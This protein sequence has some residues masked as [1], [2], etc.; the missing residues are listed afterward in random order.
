MLAPPPVL[1]LVVLIV[2]IVGGEV[3]SL[4][5][6]NMIYFIKQD[7]INKIL[8]ITFLI[9]VILISGGL[10]LKSGLSKI[11]GKDLV[12]A[13]DEIDLTSFFSAPT[14]VLI[15]SQTNKVFVINRR[16]NTITIFDGGEKKPIINLPTGGKGAVKAFM[17]QSGDIYVLNSN[18]YITIFPGLGLK[19]DFGSDSVRQILESRKS[20]VVGLGPIAFAEDSA[21]Q[22]LYVLNE[23][24]GTLAIVDLGKQNIKI[25]DIKKIKIGKRP[26]TLAINQNTHKVYVVNN[27]DGNL[28]IFDGKTDELIKNLSVGKPFFGLKISNDDRVFV[29][30]GG[31][32]K[33]YVIDGLKDEITKEFKSGGRGSMGMEINN[34]TD[35]LYISNYFD[36]SLSVV[37]A[38]NYAILKNIS[39]PVGANSATPAVDQNLNLIFVANTET[40]NIS[41]IDGRRDEIIT[42]TE[43]GAHP[44]TPEI[45]SKTGEVYIPN[46]KSDS[47]T[48]I[49]R[50]KDGN[51]QEQTIP[52]QK[53][54]VSTGETFS[55]PFNL[56]LNEKDNEIYI[57]NK[58]GGDFIIVDTKN[59]KIK[60]KI[61]VGKN[62]S[63]MIFV[64]ETSDIFVASEDE[65]N[66]IQ[67]NLLSK[68][69][70]IIPVGNRP[71]YLLFNIKTK[72][73]YAVNY[74]NGDISV[75]D[76]ER[77]VNFSRVS[78]NGIPPLKTRETSIQPSFQAIALNSKDNKIYICDVKNNEIGI[79]NGETDEL[80]QKIKVEF[81]PYNLLY[82]KNSNQLYVTSRLSDKLTVIDGSSDQVKKTL[83]VGSFP[84]YISLDEL[85]NKVYVSSNDGIK[86]IDSDSLEIISSKIYSSGYAIK[87]IIDQGRQKLFILTGAENIL[88]IASLEDRTPLASLP[89]FRMSPYLINLGFGRLEDVVFNSKTNK[90]FIALAWADSLAVIDVG[91]VIRFEAVISN[92]GIEKNPFQKLLREKGSTEGFPR[93]VQKEVHRRIIHLVLFVLII[94]VFIALIT[95]ILI[96]FLK[97]KK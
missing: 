24:E 89:I 1:L 86:I 35:K 44:L 94:C 64:P 13:A 31:E 71:L 38:R 70:K 91:G 47:I 7:K 4:K 11:L 29:L 32:D 8:V 88:D 63:E 53:E 77:G 60:E 75:I 25:A 12:F 73:L 46:Y 19:N 67:Y 74:D 59:Y 61:S 54:I 97:N 72:K 57:L 6:K 17:N 20:V 68:S 30:S 66:V 83:T 18:S 14:R 3:L 41:I 9:F 56:A 52:N 69:K 76:I 80:I 87:T 82:D 10:F 50:D 22:K 16:S 95:A 49:S 45:N 65:N 79:I 40:H 96:K 55:F 26:N 5:I 37:D 62:P 90:L 92:E 51:F 36:N 23:G 85:Q 48:I 84:G 81:A 15:N 28:F 58:Y 42:T 43:T 27:E 2:L 93:P 33:I 78:L 21:L 34:F 39:L